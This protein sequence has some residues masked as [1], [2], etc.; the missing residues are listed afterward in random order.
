[1][2]FLFVLLR[3]LS[4]KVVQSQNKRTPLLTEITYTLAMQ[5]GRVCVYLESRF[6]PEDYLTFS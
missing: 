4:I 5:T 3:F 1:M 6:V 2:L